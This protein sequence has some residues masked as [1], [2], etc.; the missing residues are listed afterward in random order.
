MCNDDELSQDAR[1]IMNSAR[2]T[3]EAIKEEMIQE[4]KEQA[5]QLIVAQHAQFEREHTFECRGKMTSPVTTV[6]A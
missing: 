1:A 5:K 6:S 4:K 3:G 2:D